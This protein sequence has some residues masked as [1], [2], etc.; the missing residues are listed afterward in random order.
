[1]TTLAHFTRCYD[2]VLGPEHCAKFIETFEVNPQHHTLHQGGFRFAEVNVTQK[3]PEIHKAAFN[4]ILPF[5]NQYAEDVGVGATW[6]EQLG[7]EELRMKRYLPNGSDEFP[8]HVDVMD[9]ASARRFLVAFL[10]LNDVA[11]GG[12]TDFPGMEQSF[13]PTA[14]SLLMFPPLWPWLHAGKPPI[15]GPKYILGTYLHYT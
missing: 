13:R 9:H 14:G 8:P 5:F 12:E 2:G 3:W 10:Y 4:A 1:M 7:F 6:P 15:S 11:E